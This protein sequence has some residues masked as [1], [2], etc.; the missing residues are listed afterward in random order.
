MLIDVIEEALLANADV[1]AGEALELVQRAAGV[2]EA[3]A[4]HLRDLHAAG[5]DHRAKN[6]ARLIADTA[7]GMLI[8]LDAVYGAEVESL[9][10]IHHGHGEVE[11]FPVAHAAENDGHAHRGH[12][13]I[14]DLSAGIALYHEIYF[15]GAQ[16]A[17][18]AFLYDEI[19]HQH[20][21]YLRVISK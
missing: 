13:I 15:F 21:M 12:L 19:I 16:F 17:A 6:K 3:A 18:V 8:G 1:E 11:R 4:G 5:R 9:T 7:G 2:A 14:G 20:V 10:R